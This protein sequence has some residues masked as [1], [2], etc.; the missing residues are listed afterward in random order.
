MKKN[1][2]YGFGNV[3]LDGNDYSSRCKE[4]NDET[5]TLRLIGHK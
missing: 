4:L 3:A 2:K 5:P 1:N